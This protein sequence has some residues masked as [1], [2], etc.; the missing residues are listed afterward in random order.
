MSGFWLFCKWT[1]EDCNLSLFISFSVF[2]FKFVLVEKNFSNPL[3]LL[4]LCI[5]WQRII[6]VYPVDSTHRTA[7][8][9]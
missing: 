1:D 6:H 8:L 2:F 4:G 9:R 5:L 3:S 7:R